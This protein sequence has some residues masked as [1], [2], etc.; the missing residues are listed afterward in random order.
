MERMDKPKN[1]T[2]VIKKE[3]SYDSG[4]IDFM[5]YTYSY[6]NI[7]I[8]IHL[9]NAFI[10]TGTEIESFLKFAQVNKLTFATIYYNTD[11]SADILFLFI[12]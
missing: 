4:S 3:E 10:L 6:T 2:I 8:T 12:N 11:D 9:Q 7:G 5:D 1:G